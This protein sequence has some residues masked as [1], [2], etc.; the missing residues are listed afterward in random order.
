[1]FTLE[2]VQ[3][4]HLLVGPW[5]DPGGPWGSLGTALELLGGSWA[6]LFGCRRVQLSLVFLGCAGLQG[7]GGPWGASGALGDPW[8]VPR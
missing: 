5:G 8:G 3:G 4:E 7:F 6:L 1:M 2:A